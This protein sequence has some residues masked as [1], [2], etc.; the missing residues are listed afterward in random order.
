MLAFSALAAPTASDVADLLNESGSSLP[1]A[2]L[3]RLGSGVEPLLKAV[4][5]ETSQPASRRGRAVSGLRC[6]ATPEVQ[7]W[8]QAWLE[9]ADTPLIQ[10]KAAWSLAN[11]F[12][13]KSMPAL[14]RALASG[15]PPEVRSDVAR[16]L[17]SLGAV[18]KP[19]LAERLKLEKDP[20]V[21]AAL[22]AALASADH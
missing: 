21:K 16:A 13:D 14:E 7:G 2:D 11:A 6:Y 10:R 9:G 12:G 18:A 5:E 4:V 19:L 20:S 22:E 17:A 1:C 15:A 8:L 3:T